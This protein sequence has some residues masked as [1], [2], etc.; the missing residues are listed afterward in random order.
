MIDQDDQLFRELTFLGER[1]H[2]SLDDL[3]DLDHTVRRR[4]IA[5]LADSDG[6]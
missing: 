1:L 6:Q 2:W 3:L 5:E 4:F